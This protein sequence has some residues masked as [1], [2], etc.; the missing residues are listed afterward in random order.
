[1]LGD[2]EENRVF[3]SKKELMTCLSIMS[4]RKKFQ[5]KVFKSNTSFIVV[6]CVHPSCSWRVRANKLI[7]SEYWMVTKHV[8]KHTCPTDFK[9]T[10]RRQATSWVV[11][12]CIK[13][14]FIN[15]GRVFRPRD[16]MDD[17]KQ[18][19]GVELNYS[20]AWRGR[21]CAYENLR[22]GTPEQSYNLLPGY[23]HMLMQ[24]NPGSV[25]N[26][27]VTD[28]NKFQYLFIAF[29]A[30][31]QGFSYCR[32]V[33]SID[34]TH[35][36]GKYRGVL[37]TAVC[38]DANQQIF[39]LAIGVGDSENDAAW[40]WFLKRVKDV[41]G[42]NPALVIVSDRHRSIRS[43]V[44][45]A[46]PRAF[47][48]ICIYHL[49]NNL[50]TKFKSKNKELEQHYIAAAKAYNLQEF[51]V[52]FY[53]LCSAVPGAKEYLE[54]VGLDRWTRSHAPCRRYNIM[55]T[56]ISESFNAVLVKVRELP[57]TAFVNEVRLLCQRW[58]QQRRTK[59]NGCS[60][61]MST[62]VENKLEQRR[63]RAQTMDVICADQYTFDVVDGDRN[64]CVDMAL[65][66]CTCRKFQ[67]DQ[68]PC[69]HVLAVVRKT[70]YDP[71]DLCSLYYTREFWCETYRGVIQ[72]IPHI[73]SWVVPPPISTFQLN[74]P[75]VRT[76][77]GRRRKRRLPL[78]GEELTT[79]KCSRCK[80][81][82]HNRATCQNP[83]A[84]RQSEPGPSLVS[85]IAGASSA[86]ELG[87]QTYPSPSM[88]PPVAAAT[89]P[90][91]V[92]HPTDPS[93]TM[94][95]PIAAAT[96]GPHFGQTLADS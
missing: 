36:K 44:E 86:T 92:G 55:T 11:G 61:R 8:N 22:L 64:Y 1:M 6:R 84:L 42:E 43:A 37:F 10:R 32:P 67:L 66:T 47:H 49:L 21:E 79:P 30:S 48:G 57:I 27:E 54:S 65:W 50:K 12:E 3:R 9:T 63:D 28:G 58:F 19:Y 74:P 20:V 88:P 5:Y 51:H 85:P 25:V 56:N 35:L 69:D 59:A 33:I 68:L 13:R 94:P 93:P 77:A 95:S 17:M 71:Y 29:A 40:T 2:I 4:M 38:H 90:P 23:L 31:I 70:Q 82:G 80:G 14:R 7:E 81:K 75:D 45:E 91:D 18:R 76:V 16:V 83:I 15:P 46:F 53:T 24:T 73:S 87:H 39:P 96:A 34:A 41:F 78:M 52:L 26:L 60:S 89:A 62:D 72:P